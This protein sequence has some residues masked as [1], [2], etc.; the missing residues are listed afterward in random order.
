MDNRQHRAEILARP[1]L[2][3]HICPITVRKLLSAFRAPKK[4]L[5]ASLKELQQVEDIKASSALAIDEL[6]SWDLIN[7]ELAK[8]EELDVGCVTFDRS[9]Y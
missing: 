3:Q 4:I 9:A 7:R 1:N 8:I 5:A 2:Y 6:D